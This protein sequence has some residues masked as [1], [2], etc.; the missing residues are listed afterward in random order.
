MVF[1]RKG[2]GGKKRDG[3]HILQVFSCKLRAIFKY[4][5]L[6]VDKQVLSSSSGCVDKV[7]EILFL[8]VLELIWKY[9]IGFLGGRTPPSLTNT[10][11]HNPRL[12]PELIFNI[13]NFLYLLDK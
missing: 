1:R 5:H 12:F 3:K 8:N 4:I 11:T 10:H 7:L 9:F 2:G 13:F 6:D